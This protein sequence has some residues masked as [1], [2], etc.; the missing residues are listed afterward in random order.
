MNVTN[1][2]NDV[3]ATDSNGDGILDSAASGIGLQADDADADTDGDGI[4]DVA[5][6]GDPNNP[7]D[8]DG[9]GIIDALAPGA[10]NNAATVLSAFV[11]SDTAQGLNL[12]SLGGSVLA[13]RST[14]GGTLTAHPNGSRGIPVYNETDML[15]PDAR[16]AYPFGLVDYSVTSPSGIAAIVIQLPS[17]V[18]I[19]ANAVVR[20]L[21]ASNQW[22]TID[23]AIDHA[24][25]TITFTLQD[26][27]AFDRDPTVGVIRDPVGIATYTGGGGGGGCVLSS[28]SNRDLSMLLIGAAIV[29]IGGRRRYTRR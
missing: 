29:L 22:V 17:T 3:A 28:N 11:T 15:V 2:D 19:P 21:S 10:D 25:G 9:D 13:I 4:S 1:T 23:A 7:T 6:A 27:D 24:A 5:E 16:V 18:T 8:S 12:T 14:G 26:N 20:K